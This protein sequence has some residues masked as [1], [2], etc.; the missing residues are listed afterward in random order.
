MT[1]SAVAGEDGG[2]AGGLG[3]IA[4]AQVAVAGGLATQASLHRS[5]FHSIS[6]LI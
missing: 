6:V 5:A 1:T 4:G 3:A 2:V